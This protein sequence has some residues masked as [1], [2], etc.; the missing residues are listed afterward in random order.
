MQYIRY[1]VKLTNKKSSCL[2]PWREYFALGCRQDS[3]VLLQAQGAD[4]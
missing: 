3:L 2:L 4:E 1:A